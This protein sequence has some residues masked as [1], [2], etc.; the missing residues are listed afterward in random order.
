MT[1][2]QLSYFV[3]AIREA[4]DDDTPRLVAAD[5]L[6]DQGD[7]ESLARAELIRLQ[8]ANITQASLARIHQLLAFIPHVQFGLPFSKRATRASARIHRGFAESMEGPVNALVKAMRLGAHRVNPLTLLTCDVQPSENLLTVLRVKGVIQHVEKIGMHLVDVIKLAEK[9]EF[10]KNMRALQVSG[11]EYFHA[12]INQRVKQ[13][14]ATILF[15]LPS[16]PQQIELIMA[17]VQERDMPSSPL[18]ALT[19]DSNTQ[20]VAV[21][22]G[23]TL[24][25]V[26]IHDRLTYRIEPANDTANDI[27]LRW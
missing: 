14:T 10:P 6:E 21:I 12:G 17:N 22:S 8:C 23:P 16:P 27:T 5:W 24:Q 9:G 20:V 3:P 18:P 2:T 4:G 1:V 19:Q 7:A 25:E 11:S 13:S 26:H 15:H